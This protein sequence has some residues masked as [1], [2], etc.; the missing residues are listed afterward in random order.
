MKTQLS[1]T[2]RNGSSFMNRKCIELPNNCCKHSA[3]IAGH[4][5]LH[6]INTSKCFFYI[7][8]STR[9]SARTRRLCWILL[10]FY[11]PAIILLMVM[12]YIEQPQRDGRIESELRYHILLVTNRPSGSLTCLV[13]STVYET[14]VYR[15]I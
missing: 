15:I 10:W 2:K 13:Q 12:A 1:F 5:N 11:G 9:K 3:T 8:F 4:V 7:M 14:S 6:L